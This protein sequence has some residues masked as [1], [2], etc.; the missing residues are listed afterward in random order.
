MR[1]FIITQN[2][3]EEDPPPVFSRSFK[4]EILGFFEMVPEPASCFTVAEWEEGGEDGPELVTRLTGEE[5]LD[6]N[7]VIETRRRLR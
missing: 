6:R 1:Y 5:W 3:T 2:N 7:T 4:S